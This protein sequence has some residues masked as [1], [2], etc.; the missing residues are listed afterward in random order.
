MTPLGPQLIGETEKGLNAVLRRILQGTG[1]SE[2]EWVVLRLAVGNDAG[3]DLG[4]LVA[5]KT[6]LADAR[7]LVEALA[8]R[9]LVAGNTASARGR[10]LVA[11]KLREIAEVTASIWEGLDAGDVAATERTLQVI[12]ARSRALLA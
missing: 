12:A 11:E 7:E 4:A 3:G 6:H 5:H 1:L 2:P 10:A 8:G 9:G